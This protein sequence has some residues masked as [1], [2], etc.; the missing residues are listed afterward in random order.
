MSSILERLYI[1]HLFK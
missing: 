1:E